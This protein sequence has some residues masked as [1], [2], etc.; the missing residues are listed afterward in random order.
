MNAETPNCLEIPSKEATACAL[1]S[2]YSSLF[3]NDSSGNFKP[4]RFITVENL[5]SLNNSKSESLSLISPR[6]KRMSLGSLS[7]EPESKLSN[8]ISGMP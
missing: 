6:T 1:T 3:S 5:N 8:A 2:K 7:A 4:A